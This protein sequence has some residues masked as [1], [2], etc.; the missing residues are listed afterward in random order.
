VTTYLIKLV[1][2]VIKIVLS[3]SSLP[4]SQQ[5]LHGPN[6]LGVQRGLGFRGRERDRERGRAALVLHRLT[7]R[8]TRAVC[9]ISRDCDYSVTTS[10]F[11]SRWLAIAANICRP[12][13]RGI[14]LVSSSG[15]KLAV[16]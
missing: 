2:W 12:L 6:R 4:S 10:S 8:L 9:L 11:V 15:A 3:F 1:R 5:A 16:C 13:Q 7:M 14:L